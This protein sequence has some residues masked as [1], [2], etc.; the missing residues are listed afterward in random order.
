MDCA[1]CKR[2]IIKREC[3]KRVYERAALDM[4]TGVMSAQRRE[5][6]RLKTLADEAWVD[7]ELTETEII[8]HQ[9]THAVLT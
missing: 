7:L 1:E 2:L 9:D 4:K 5:Y 6:I 3:L 8:Q